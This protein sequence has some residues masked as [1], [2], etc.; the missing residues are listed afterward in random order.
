MFI[1]GILLKTNMVTPGAKCVDKASNEKIAQM[2]VQSYKRTVP[3]AMP[4]F[5]SNV[6]LVHSLKTSLD[7]NSFLKALFSYRVVNLL[8]MRQKICKR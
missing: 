1:E 7:F 2:S 5:P 6:T 4:G 3:S 8:W